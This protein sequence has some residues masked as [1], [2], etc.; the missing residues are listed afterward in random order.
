MTGEA[1]DGL[2]WGRLMRFAR[3]DDTKIN[4]CFWIITMMLVLIGLSTLKL[5]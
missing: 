1:R 4:P 5:R 2:I 3:Y